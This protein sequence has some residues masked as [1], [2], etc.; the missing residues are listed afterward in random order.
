MYIFSV[1]VCSLFIPTYLSGTVSRG[2]RLYIPVARYALQSLN[3]P[4]E[5][6]PTYL[7]IYIYQVCSPIRGLAADCPI[8]KFFYLTS[9]DWS[10]VVQERERERDSLP[11]SLALAIASLPFGLHLV[12]EALRV[13]P[14]NLTISA[15]QWQF[16]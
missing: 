4:R 9:K 10:H 16:S 14:N 15:T 11:P 6:Q 13:S 5:E 12:L 1:C 2:A 3:L 8:L 7:S